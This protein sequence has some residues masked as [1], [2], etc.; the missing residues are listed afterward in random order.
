[1]IPIKKISLLILIISFLMFPQK[2]EHP[3]LIVGIVIDQMRYDYLI[4]FNRYFGHDGFNKLTNNGSDFTHAHFNYVPTFT[5]PGHSSIYTGTTPFYHGIIANDWFDR[6]KNHMVSSVAGDSFQS[7]GIQSDEGKRSPNNLLA[8]T[9]TDQLKIATNG[10]AKVVSISLKDRAAIL[11]GGHSADEAF[12]YSNKSGNFISSTYYMNKLPDWVKDFYQ[13]KLPDSFISQDW[14]LSLPDSDY[15]ISSPDETKYE[16]DVFNEG[17]TSF[18]H[19]LKNVDSNLKYS[20]LIKTPFGNQ[21]V[22]EFAKAAIVNE[23]LGKNSVPDFLAVSFSSTDYIGHEYGPNS[24]EIEDTYI[25]LD[26]QIAELLSVL[27]KQIGKGNYL[28][29]L[30]AD[31]GIMESPGYLEKL[32]INGENFDTKIFY[33]SLKSFALK[34]YNDENIIKNYSNQQIFL[35][36]EIVKNKNLNLVKVEKNFSDYFMNHFPQISLV[37]TRNE[38]QKEI[39]ERNSNNLILNGFNFKRSGDIVFEFEPNIIPDHKKGSTHGSTYNYDTH[40]PIIFYGWHI[41]RQ[42][43]NTPVYIVDIAPTIA[44]L[45]GIT[46]PNACIGIPIIK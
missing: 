38:L 45:I 32:K 34:N 46:E 12:W 22:L 24:F 44:N 41:P 35:N 33:D 10:K 25:K 28:L 42:K 4:K 19:S 39:A 13:R 21:L 30:T 37:L 31:H 23:N 26:K 40:I 7:V 18:P 29:F 14:D 11:P 1:M 8:T 43:V 2:T 5:A 20:A 16:S 6:I 3:K 17:R 9:I 36:H 15:Q 27:D